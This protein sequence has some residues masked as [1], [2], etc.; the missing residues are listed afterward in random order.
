MP[1]D[2]PRHVRGRNAGKP[3]RKRS[4]DIVEA[5]ASKL[6]QD[7]ENILRLNRKFKSRLTE[8]DLRDICVNIYIGEGRFSI[9]VCTCIRETTPAI[10]TGRDRFV[11][12][13][14]HGT[15][16][17]STHVSPTYSRR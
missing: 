15:S 8:I 6:R 7:R 17:N 16:L 5:S 11:I 14:E 9:D 13:S 3:L 2:I 12:F 1:R 4:S 10:V